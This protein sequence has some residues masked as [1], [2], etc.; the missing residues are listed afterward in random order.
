MVKKIIK[1]TVFF[2]RQN[3]DFEE[4][5]DIKR[6]YTHPLYNNNQLYNDIVVIELGRRVEFD[7]TKYGHTP[8]CLDRGDQDLVGL[9][10]T[11]QVKHIS[12]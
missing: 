10:A 4:V 2:H 7:F 8:T 9:I 6:V 12:I 11:V 1:K 3:S 5:L